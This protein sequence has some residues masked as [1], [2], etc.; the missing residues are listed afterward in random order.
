MQSCA[1]L[2]NCVTRQIA[3][4]Q[5]RRE[6]W[7]DQWKQIEVGEMTI[8]V[9]IACSKSKRIVEPLPALVWIEQ[10]DI[11]QWTNAWLKQRRIT[12]G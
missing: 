4:R 1:G 12:Q 11:K 6:K 2:T 9:L 10:M 3:D 8:Y 5:T 7:L